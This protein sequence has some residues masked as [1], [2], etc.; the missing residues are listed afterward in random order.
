MQGAKWENSGEEWVPQP[1]ADVSSLSPHPR[2]LA[3]KPIFGRFYQLSPLSYP[4][5]PG[6]RQ[7][8]SDPLRTTCAVISPNRHGGVAAATP[9]PLPRSEFSRNPCI[10]K[11]LPSGDPLAS[12]GEVATP[13]TMER[14]SKPA[15]R[16]T[17][18]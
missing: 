16:G 7:L 1:S 2:T 4:C 8:E 17:L 13:G 18:D 3:H 15:R 6:Q 9:L 10:R 14:S 12:C 5:P 11:A